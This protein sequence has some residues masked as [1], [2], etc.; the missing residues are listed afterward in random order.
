MIK[1]IA[2]DLDGTLLSPDGTISTKNIKT[3]K[4]AQAK[5]IEV[6][7]ATGRSYESAQNAIQ[8]A[9]LTT[10]IICLNGANVY[11]SNGQISVEKPLTKESVT[12]IL[13]VVDTDEVY[14][15]LYTNKGIFSTDRTKFMQVLVKILATEYK[16]YTE[17]MIKERAEQR[18][19]EESFTFTTDFE[20]LLKDPAIVPYKIL[21]FSLKPEGLLKLRESFTGHPS[22]HVTSSGFD[23]VEFNHPDAKKGI[24]LKAFAE[25]KAIELSEIMAIGDNE[26][27]LS[28]LTMVGRGVAMANAKQ[29]VK[30]A[31]QY[32]TSSHEEDG[33]SQAIETMLLEN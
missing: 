29:L 9:G 30:D 23:N 20:G 21:T 10:D 4:K 32:H 33:V 26:N 13:H 19:Q 3:I 14:F 15:E 12:E 6:I 28:M 1:L 11:D 8:D 16:Q 24:A 31:C 27:D 2:T 5:G 18:F 7:V 17:E 25:Q 22:I